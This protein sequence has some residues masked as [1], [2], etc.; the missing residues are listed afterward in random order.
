MCKRGIIGLVF[1]LAV[2]V[3]SVSAEPVVTTYWDVFSLKDDSGIPIKGLVL[4]VDFGK[5]FFQAYGYVDVGNGTAAHGSGYA[6]DNGFTIHLHLSQHFLLLLVDGVTL[7]GDA[8]LYGPDNM[9]I[10]KGTVRLASIE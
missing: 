5:H 7:T 6:V 8:W 3:G 10:D 4:D 2:F 9:L 1:I